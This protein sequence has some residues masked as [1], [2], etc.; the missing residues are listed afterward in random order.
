M[1]NLNLILMLATLSSPLFYNESPVPVLGPVGQGQV[2]DGGVKATQEELI[3]GLK[4]SINEA[5]IQISKKHGSPAEMVA[6]ESSP[7]TGCI[8]LV[9][10]VPKEKFIETFLLALNSDNV[11]APLDAYIPVSKEIMS[12]LRK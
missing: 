5:L 6:I 4:I 7:L 8:L 10:S 3:S 1:I 9:I 11:W 12:K 2:S